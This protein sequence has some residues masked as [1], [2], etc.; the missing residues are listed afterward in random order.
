[1]IP[2]IPLSSKLKELHG[3]CLRNGETVVADPVAM[4]RLLSA[5]TAGYAFHG[6]M[7]YASALF[8]A[9][10]LKASP[11]W[12]SMISGF[13]ESGQTHEAFPS[14]CI[15]ICSYVPTGPGVDGMGRRLGQVSLDCFAS[16]LGIGRQRQW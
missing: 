8:G 11:L 12:N 5:I 15:S 16:L 4:D 3:F 1:M 7:D 14:Q 6:C 10:K 13:L 2:V 9:V